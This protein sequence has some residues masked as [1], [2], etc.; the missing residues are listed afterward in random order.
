MKNL[1]L[2]LISFFIFSSQSLAE[3]AKLRTTQTQTAQPTTTQAKATNSQKEIEDPDLKLSIEELKKKYPISLLNE[4]KKNYKP[5]QK[6]NIDDYSIAEIKAVFL[7]AKENFVRYE[8]AKRVVKTRIGGFVV[9]K[10]AIVR[11]RHEL[12]IIEAACDKLGVTDSS[13]L[14]KNQ[15]AMQ[16]FVFSDYRIR[17]YV[18]PFVSVEAEN[19][20]TVNDPLEYEDRN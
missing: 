2:S 4:K 12:L 5:G 19:C 9:D 17:K 6:I 1:L 7:N 14:T 20:L 10:E 3:E 13:Q 15:N 8:P 18:R 11:N 16:L